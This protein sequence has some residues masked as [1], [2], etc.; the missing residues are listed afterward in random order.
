MNGYYNLNRLQVW[1]GLKERKKLPESSILQHNTRSSRRNQT[2]KCYIVVGKVVDFDVE[3]ESKLDNAL[4]LAIHHHNVI[5]TGQGLTQ[6]VD[7]DVT[8]AWL[9]LVLREELTHFVLHF[10]VIEQDCLP[11][12]L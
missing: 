10:P 7:D 12:R 4:F 3:V 9:I 6:K 5:A 8:V 11:R 1:D 2:S